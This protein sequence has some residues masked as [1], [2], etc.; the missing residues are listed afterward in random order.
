[1]KKRFFS[2]LVCAV[3]AACAVIDQFTNDLTFTIS[4]EA[5][6][7][8]ENPAWAS[9]DAVRVLSSTRT[10]GSSFNLST[11]VRTNKGLFSGEKPGS[12]PF[13]LVWPASVAAE[14]SSQEALTATLSAQQ[15][16]VKDGY[17]ASACLYAATA[18]TGG[19]YRLYT[20][21]AVLGVPLTGA[22]SISRLTLSTPEGHPLCGKA[23]VKPGEDPT[24]SI[25]TEAGYD[26]TLDCGKGVKLGSKAVW[27]RFVIPPAALAGGAVLQ[28]TDTEGGAMSLAL[29]PAAPGRG[30][31]LTLPETAYVQAE[32]PYLN[33]QA[34]GLYTLSKSG[35]ATPVYTY[36]SG[37]D[38]LALIETPDALQWR[39]QCLED[40]RVLRVTVPPVRS[41]AFDAL[42]SAIGVPA[43]PEGMLTLSPVK[44]EDGLEWCIDASETYLLILQPAL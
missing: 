7:F 11:G 33:Q 41:A 35:K 3:L 4:R 12:A 26:L 18:E 1:M 30:G 15:S 34:P 29:E 20:P 40:G 38:Q 23:Q 9:G 16:Y 25:D 14:F 32:P 36:V 10:K 27:F 31:V 28:V 6:A 13:H 22:M 42:F 44:C 21:M 39:L 37:R 19:E 8:A 5:T 24:L 2:I 17:D 43:C